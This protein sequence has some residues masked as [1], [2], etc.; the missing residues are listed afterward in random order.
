MSVVALTPGRGGSLFPPRVHTPHQVGSGSG[1]TPIESEFQSEEPAVH[2]L[3]YHS[4]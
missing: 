4:P 1:A 3:V 2:E